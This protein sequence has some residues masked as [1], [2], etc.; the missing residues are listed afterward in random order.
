MR[1][2]D[3]H[4]WTELEVGVISV[5]QDGELVADGKRGGSGRSQRRGVEVELDCIVREIEGGHWK[6]GKGASSCSNEN[7]SAHPRLGT[8]VG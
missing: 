8:L 4:E 2:A 3:T 6:S 1:P 7:S 5:G